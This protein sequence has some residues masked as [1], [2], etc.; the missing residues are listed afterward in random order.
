MSRLRSPLRQKALRHPG[1]S[2]DAQIER[3]IDEGAIG[4]Y[5]AVACLW[6]IA[7]LECWGY[8]V[9]MPRRPWIFLIL[10]VAG[11]VWFA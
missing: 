11:T 1:Q 2:I 4:P 7:L 10:A 8:W 9:D 5:A 3:V 6:G